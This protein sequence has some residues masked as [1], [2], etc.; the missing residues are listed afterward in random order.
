[1]AEP[2]DFPEANILVQR[3]LLDI[4]RDKSLPATIEVWE[5]GI[6]AGAVTEIWASRLE[7]TRLDDLTL[8]DWG[9]PA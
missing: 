2:F 8:A 5:A 6:K 4:F 1:M 3:V 9:Q 7:T